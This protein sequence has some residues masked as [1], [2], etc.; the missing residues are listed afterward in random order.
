MATFRKERL[1]ALIKRIIGDALLTEVKDPRIGFASVFRVE[2]SRDYSVADVFI[3][4]IGDESQ[5]KKTI[6]GLYSA[7]GYIRSMLGKQ[8]KLRVAPE[9]KFHLDDSIEKGAGM[10]DLLDKLASE[11]HER[12]ELH[13]KEDDAKK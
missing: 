12:S 6:K 7:S 8:V 13:D 1:E 3:S 5:K 4:V 9:L 10:V 11:A 2:V